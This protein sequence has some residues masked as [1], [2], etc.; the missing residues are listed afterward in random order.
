MQVEKNNPSIDQKEPTTKLK[1]GELLVDARNRAAL[2]Q[3]DISEQI[4]LP[5]SIINAL[6]NDQFDKLP[7]SPYVRGYLKSYARLVSVDPD[8][9]VRNYNTLHHIEPEV[10][11]VVNSTPNRNKCQYDAIF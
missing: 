10:S 7:E 3:T 8:E 4:N 5:I 2:N 1:I 11:K 6:E 9:I